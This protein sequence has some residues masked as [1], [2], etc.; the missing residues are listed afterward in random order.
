MCRCGPFEAFD[1]FLRNALYAPLV[2]DVRAL[3]AERAEIGR[4]EKNADARL[5]EQGPAELVEFLH[6]LKERLLNVSFDE[7]LTDAEATYE[8]LHNRV[9][10][11]ECA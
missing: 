4:L 10:T 1:E 7:P 11:A 8:D 6:E 9:L 2:A 3:E 5:R